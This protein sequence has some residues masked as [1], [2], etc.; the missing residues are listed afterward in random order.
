MDPQLWRLGST[1]RPPASALF[2]YVLGPGLPFVAMAS[3]TSDNHPVGLCRTGP[4]ARSQRWSRETDSSTAA[5][6]VLC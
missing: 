3:S 5:A 1:C 4:C 2:R 6:L